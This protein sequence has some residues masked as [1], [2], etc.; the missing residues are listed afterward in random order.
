MA[1]STRMDWDRG[2]NWVILARDGIEVARTT[3]DESMELGAVRYA[4]EE[5]MRQA[6]PY[7][8]SHPAA[9]RPNQ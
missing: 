4:A 3:L 1:Y 8:R 9:L 7:P 2:H 6:G 5:L